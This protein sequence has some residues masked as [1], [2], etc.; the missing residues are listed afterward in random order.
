MF[1]TY[2]KLLTSCM[3][4]TCSIIAYADECSSEKI[5]GYC[6]FDNVVNTG[7]SDAF[8]CTVTGNK[9]AVIIEFDNKSQKILASGFKNGLLRVDNID[10]LN[11]SFFSVIKNPKQPITSDPIEVTYYLKQKPGQSSSIKC[12]LGIG[13]GRIT[14]E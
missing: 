2:I 4:L 5:S 7:Q 6:A 1:I 11:E 14:W 8:H 3:L 10:K 12:D 9:A 13:K